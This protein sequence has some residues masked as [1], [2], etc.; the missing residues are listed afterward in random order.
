MKAS[1]RKSLGEYKPLIVHDSGRTEVVGKRG[2]TEYWIAL[3][4]SG[5]TYRAHR[6]VTFPSRKEAIDYAQKHIDRLR[7]FTARRKKER[8]E[9][10]ARYAAQST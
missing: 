3:T 5:E 9:R 4:Y 7:E 10:H 6:G 1:A 8:E 2:H